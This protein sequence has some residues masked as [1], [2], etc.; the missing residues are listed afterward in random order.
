MQ[1]RDFKEDLALHGIKMLF[2]MNH[3]LLEGKH[4]RTFETEIR[5]S[6]EMDAPIDKA[7]RDFPEEYKTVSDTVDESALA[8]YREMIE[9][10]Q[11]FEA[12]LISEW[13][14]EDSD[15]GREVKFTIE[16]RIAIQE[17]EGLQSDKRTAILSMIAES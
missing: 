14:K 3:I 8:H 16:E 15:S 1:F 13:A 6:A 17:A 7:R 4:E 2:F 5:V 11:K 9:Q 12:W 10:H